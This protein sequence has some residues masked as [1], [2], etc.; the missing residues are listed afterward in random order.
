MLALQHLPSQ[1]Q[2]SGEGMVTKSVCEIACNMCSTISECLNE[3]FG[4]YIHNDMVIVRALS[5]RC[6][7]AHADSTTTLVVEA[8]F[9]KKKKKNDLLNTVNKLPLTGFCSSF[10]I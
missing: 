6:R 10:K 5:Y 8:A 2:G 7:F 3:H 9:A 1:I 4:G